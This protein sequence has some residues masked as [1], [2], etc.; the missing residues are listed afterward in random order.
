MK[1]KEL[2]QPVP[3]TESQSDLN[4]HTTVACDGCGVSPVI[5]VRYKCVVC[6]NFDYCE[7]CEERL[8]H[9][10]PFIKIVRP[11][12]APASIIT[13]VYDNS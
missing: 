4:T 12:D 11:Q 1:C 5:G 2:G 13:G 6:K 8:G 3:Q 7:I 9:E 10:H